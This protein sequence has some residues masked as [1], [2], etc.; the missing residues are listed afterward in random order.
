MTRAGLRAWFRRWVQK[1]VTSLLLTAGLLTSLLSIGGHSRFTTVGRWFATGGRADPAVAHLYAVRRGDLFEV[2][3]PNTDSWDAM[4]RVIRDRPAE[5]FQVHVQYGSPVARG[6]YAPTRE[7]IRWSLVAL[8][9][10]NPARITDH[11]SAAIRQAVVEWWRAQPDAPAPDTL[12]RLRTA[13]VIDTRP[14]WSGYLH[15]ALALLGLFL[16]LYSL[17]W[18]P[19]VGPYLT[20]TRAQRRLARGCCP[21]CNYSIAGLPEPVCPECGKGWNITAEDDLPA[22]PGAS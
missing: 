11:E 1:P 4:A 2:E 5:V 20:R 10:A 22:S 3:D 12:N 14:L 17:A 8:P 16:F 13:D 18:I 6:F 21:H 9:L 15:N 7:V 19:R